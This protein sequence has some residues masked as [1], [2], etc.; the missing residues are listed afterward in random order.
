M[1]TRV[2]PIQ[3]VDLVIDEATGKLCVIA[4]LEATPTI[5][6]G[7]VQVKD[8]TGA[9]INPATED[10]HLAATAAALAL[11]TG[12]ALTF[13]RKQFSG[14]GG[15]VVIVAAA[16]NVVARV[17]GLNLVVAGA[18]A[19]LTLKDS[20]AATLTVLGTFPVG[21]GIVL[22]P[23]A[24][25]KLAHAQAATGKGLSLVVGAGATVTGQVLYATGAS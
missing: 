14:D 23:V 4:E 15:T 7:D 11:L 2:R 6:I 12:S 3:A 18:E 13:A 22:D 20:D 10:G 5:D 16:A 25:A 21:G 24:M 8:L 1:G 9:K 19:T 17:M